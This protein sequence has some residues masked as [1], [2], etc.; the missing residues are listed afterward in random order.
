VL[1]RWTPCE[2]NAGTGSQTTTVDGVALRWIDVQ[3]AGSDS[4]FS[5]ARAVSR[6][7]ESTAG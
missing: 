1:W 5:V 6:A 7:A 2:A 3:A 4:A